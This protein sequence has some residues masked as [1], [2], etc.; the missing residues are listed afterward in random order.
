VITSDKVEVE[1][2]R[3]APKLSDTGANVTAGKVK[4]LMASVETAVI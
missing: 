1:F 2:I 3:T 4:V